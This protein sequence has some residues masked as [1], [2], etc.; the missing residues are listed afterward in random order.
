MYYLHI[1]RHVEIRQKTI[2]WNS[3]RFGLFNNISQQ[4]GLKI[5]YLM[6]YIDIDESHDKYIIPH[7]S[8]T[9]PRGQSRDVTS[10]TT[11]IGRY[12]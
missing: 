6:E 10:D 12:L 9:S 1:M 8:T 2:F 5:E 11:D 4:Q 3:F 7:S